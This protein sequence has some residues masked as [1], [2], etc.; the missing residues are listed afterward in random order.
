MQDIRVAAVVCNS[1]ANKIRHNLNQLQHWVEAAARRHVRIICFPEL[2]I[3]GYTVRSPGMETETIPGTITRW[4]GELA[5]KKQMVI[6][7][8]MAEKGADGRVYA[9]HLVARPDGLLGIY[10]KLHIAPPE[11]GLFSGGD[12][13]PLFDAF[14]IRLGIQLCYDAHFPELSTIMA[15]QGAELIFMPHASPRGTSLEKYK[16]WKRHLPARAYDNSLYVVACNQTGDNGGGLVFPGLAMV[17]GPSGDIVQK[18]LTD[19]E[20]LLVADLSA[21]ALNRVRQHKMRCFFPNRRPALYKK[22]FKHPWLPLSANI[23]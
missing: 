19:T 18:D 14:G 23:R 9:V 22:A 10:R 16:S 15:T 2:N 7:A 12:C 3:C 21:S 4:I 8:G 17:I 6:L 13:V 5:K 20:G 11:S 1:P